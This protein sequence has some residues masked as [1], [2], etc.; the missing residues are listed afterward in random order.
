MSLSEEAI[1]YIICLVLG[2]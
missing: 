1:G 2:E